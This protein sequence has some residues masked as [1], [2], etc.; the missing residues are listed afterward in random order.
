[1]QLRGL[2][3]GFE[4][5]TQGT[6]KVA[7]R[8]IALFIEDTAGDPGTGGQKARALIEDQGVHILQGCT[9]SAVTIVV[10]GIAAEFERLL[11]VE[12]AAADSITGEHLNPY[13][14]R[15]AAS[16]SQDAEAGGRYAAENLGEKFAYIAPDYIWG[17]QSTAAWKRVIENYGGQ[18]LVE[19]LAP[20][21][22]L[23][24]KPYL[25][26][27]LQYDP[28]VIVQS[29]AGAGY[30]HLFSDMRDQGVFDKCRVTGGLGDREAR[31]ALG[32]DA[33]GI[34][35][36]IKYSC[37]LPKNPINDWLREAHRA[38]YAEEPDLFTGGG[39]AAAVAL[40]EALKRTGGD[41]DGNALRQ[42]MEGMSFEGPKGTYT[43]R[44][45]D[46]QALQSMYVVKMVEDPDPDNRWAMPELI[47]EFS[48]EE[49][50]PPLKSVA[51]S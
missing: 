25:D 33:V 20:P 26:D 41:P 48:P 40:T 28:D 12:P 19:V 51:S 13:V 7:N 30:R 16:V 6:M 15:T 29:W 5:A 31:H 43:F 49:T 17:Q 38:Q 42:V 4:Y 21:N 3:L 9:S 47:Q 8:P 32:L 2:K 35:G 36:A 1:M 22:T 14:F 18:T 10:A 37:I 50:A 23:D 24:F 45:E 27:L 11:L 34:I 44:L 39:F 46:H